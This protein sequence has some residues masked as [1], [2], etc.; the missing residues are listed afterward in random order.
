MP[1]DPDLVIERSVRDREAHTY[2]AFQSAMR[3]R[4]FVWARDTVA[5]HWILGGRRILD[6]GCGTGSFLAR[7]RAGR[8]ARA[9]GC[10]L[11]MESLRVARTKEGN[12][13]LV[14]ADL[15]RLPFRDQS[16]DRIA[17][18]V[19]L[20]H[21][22]PS[23]QEAALHELARVAR[24]G[25]RLAVQVYSARTSRCFEREVG[26]GRFRSGIFY[27]TF[28]VAE[29]GDLLA[30]TGWRIDRLRGFGVLHYLSHRFRGGFRIYKL[31][32]SLIVPLECLV[33]LA[34]GEG[35]ARYG[36]YLYA[37]CLRD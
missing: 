5:R 13:P 32:A 19:V 31:L 21:I 11:S 14:C 8:D 7:L 2:D 20:Q 15:T 23:L 26:A 10:D 6:A 16:F 36:E 18:L 34:S 27:Y 4:W 25:A 35:V 29:L 9:I 30:R 3:S 37:L 17:L 12:A 24:K 22:P 28:H 33:T 1:L